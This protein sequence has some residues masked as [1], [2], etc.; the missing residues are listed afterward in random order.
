[1]SSSSLLFPKLART[2]RKIFSIFRVTIPAEALLSNCLTETNQGT[3]RH[4]ETRRGVS[5][6]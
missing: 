4:A 5:Y 2:S 1:M 6:A 3:R